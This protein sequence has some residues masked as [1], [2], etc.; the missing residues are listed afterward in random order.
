MNG[1]RWKSACKIVLDQDLTAYRSSEQLQQKQTEILIKF[2]A[3]NKIWSKSGSS[4][5]RRRNNGH[6]NERT[7][8]S[9]Q[10]NCYAFQILIFGENAKTTA[11]IMIW[12]SMSQ[13]FPQPSLNWEEGELLNCTWYEN[14]FLNHSRSQHVKILSR[15]NNQFLIEKDSF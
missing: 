8:C 14:A 15:T 9:D 12:V 11:W 7:V 4:L 3:T 6:L 13:R 5:F 2:K 1:W 10:W